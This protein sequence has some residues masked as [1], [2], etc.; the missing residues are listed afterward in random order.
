MSDFP[1]VPVD[2]SVTSTNGLRAATGID[3]HVRQRVQKQVTELT[4]R[5]NRR[6]AP[7]RT[8]GHDPD[9]LGGHPAD[10][11]STLS[12]PTEG[13]DS[14]VVGG[15]I[16]L[17]R[18]S[19]EDGQSAGPASGAVGSSL[20]RSGAT[21]SRAGWCAWSTVD[22]VT[23]AGRHRGR[24]ARPGPCGIAHPRD[25]AAAGG[26]ALQQRRRLGDRD[27]LR[28]SRQLRRQ[29]RREGRGDR[30]GH[31]RARSA[32]TAG[33]PASPARSTD[34]STAANDS[35]RRPAGPRS[36]GTACST[37]RPA[38]ARLSAASWRRSR[39]EPTSRSTARSR[40]P[41]PGTEID[42]ACALVP[43][44]CVTVRRSSTCRWARRRCPTSPRWRSPPRSR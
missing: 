4:Q 37:S 32:R 17:R 16:L 36:A 35:Q 30:H 42:V 44:R 25:A 23:S 39:P 11:G 20:V 31:R 28:L 26:Q 22:D 6:S 19:W 24:A 33:S 18:A 43:P 13:P 1:A 40:R 8:R 2:L 10:A 15:E 27:L 3:A 5:R 41:A 7:T 29:R 12:R 14:L 9:T 21:P 38:T 34:P